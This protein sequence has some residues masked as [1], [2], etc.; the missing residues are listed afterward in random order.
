M[1]SMISRL[2]REPLVHFLAF[3]GL[4]FVVYYAMNPSASAPPPNVISITPKSIER[5]RT[6]FIGVWK[7]EPGEDE[8]NSLIDDAIRE[9][10]Y[11]RE[12][13]ALGLDKGDALVKRRMRLKMEFL[14]DSASSVLEPANEELE[15]FYSVN[16]ENY[17]E[18]PRVAF[19]QVF[20]GETSNAATVEAALTQMRANPDIDLYSIG[21][22][23]QLPAQ[24]GLATTDAVT[25]VFGRGF[26]ERVSALDKMIWTGP[27]EST[28][29]VH[30][31]RVLDIL[32]AQAPKLAEVRDLVLRDWRTA[33][34]GEIQDRD[35]AKRRTRYVVEIDRGDGVQAE[36]Q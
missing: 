7:R 25:G 19:E 17:L 13:V 20:L 21:P 30:I 24:L 35:Y 18:E 27:V 36:S 3:G 4:M 6:G 33:K 29:G 9:E 16:I 31:V 34:R 8:L 2:L 10:I 12:A 32:P 14:M 1:K 11:Y 23:S 26:F 22:R 5:I 15:A 28:Y